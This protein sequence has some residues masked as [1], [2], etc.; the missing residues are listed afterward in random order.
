MIDIYKWGKENEVKSGV[1]AIKASAMPDLKNISEFLANLKI[2]VMVEIGT[3]Y[4]LSAARFTQLSNKVHTFD[5]ANFPGRD[6]MWEK[7]GIRDKIC[8]HII[9][10]RWDIKRILKTIDFDFAFIDAFHNYKNVKADFK[11]VKGCK[12]VLFHDIDPKRYPGCNRFLN[13]IGG[14]VIS[15][16]IGYWEET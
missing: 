12:R 4:G 6:E 8:F 1:L 2:K 14:R 13:E 9:K 15:D 7:L 11:L 10:N 3:C 5:V 16:N